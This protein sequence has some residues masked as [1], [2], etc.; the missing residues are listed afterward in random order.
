MSLR[1]DVQRRSSSAD[2]APSAA[3][4]RKRIV[5]K[6]IAQAAD[7]AQESL[8]RHQQAERERLR[9]FGRELRKKVDRRERERLAAQELPPS[10]IDGDRGNCPPPQY[11]EAQIRYS[12][13]HGGGLGS[14]RTGSSMQS[15]DESWDKTCGDD[16]WPEWGPP[17]PPGLQASEATPG[18]VHRTPPEVLQAEGQAAAKALLARAPPAAV[19]TPPPPPAAAAAA[20]Q[21]SW[22]ES[23][24]GDDEWGTRRDEWDESWD[25]QWGDNEW[26]TPPPPAAVGHDE[27][28][29][30]AVGRVMGQAWDTPPPPAA[31]QT[32]PPPA[33]AAASSGSG[34]GSPA[35]TTSHSKG[36]RSKGG[37]GTSTST[38]S[39]KLGGPKGHQKGGEHHHWQA[40]HDA[41]IAAAIETARENCV[42]AD[43]R[44]VAAAIK[45][46][47]ENCEG[48][49]L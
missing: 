19:Q 1:L 6:R 7:T 39:G 3:E 15:S 8:E 48:W 28:W 10:S 9:E 12:E 5:R 29:G 38:K 22:D 49:T 2:E 24:P 26:G 43:P 34:S 41:I 32:P 37:T 42:D 31:V 40:R 17:P 46:A 14:A 35:A 21:G 33:A 18:E 44:A 47:R 25:K 4:M 45:K 16:E 27:S 13:A 20:V 11:T 23:W 36:G 30:Q